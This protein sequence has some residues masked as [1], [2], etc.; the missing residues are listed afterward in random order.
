MLSSFNSILLLATTC[1]GA[2]ACLMENRQPPPGKLIDVGGYS[3]HL[4]T[5]GESGPTV[6]VEHSLGGLEGY[7]LLPEIA[8]HTR[9]CIYDRA[10][11]GWSDHSPYP[12][13][14]AQIVA[15]LDYLLTQA[16]IQPP[17]ILVGNSFGSYNVR[18]YAQYFPEKV[19]GMVL[20]DGLHETAMLKMP[21]PLQLLKL[22]FLSGFVMSFIGSILGIVRL[23]KVMGVFE[24]IKRE[25]IKFPKLILKPVKRSF[26]RPK[27]WITMSREILN[28]DI[29]SRQVELA[30]YFDALPIVS[31]KAKTFF[32]PSLW[33]IFLPIKA[34]NKLREQMHSE[35]L[36][37]STNCVQIQAEKSGHFVWID[38]PEIIVNAILKILNTG[39]RN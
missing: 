14:S 2:I 6:I 16:N 22:F 38:Q 27:H 30:N 20:T 32:H 33:A 37:L 23:L 36:N 39:D 31:I 4:Y 18:L 26:C 12:R 11:Y 1:Y 7:L 9:V 29:S 28:L 10:G 13:T 15:E 35:I 5:A 3:L 24:L 17:Y 8:K 25:L 34:A 21:I 19:M